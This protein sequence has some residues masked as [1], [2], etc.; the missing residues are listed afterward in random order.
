MGLWLSYAIGIPPRRAMHLAQPDRGELQHPGNFNEHHIA[1][2]N[3]GN[4]SQIRRS[5]EGIAC[6]TD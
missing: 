1:Y 3:P 2:G 6:I 4:H 5:L